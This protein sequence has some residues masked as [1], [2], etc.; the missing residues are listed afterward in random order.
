MP[1]H[2]NLVTK[3]LMILEFLV[4]R[5]VKGGERKTFS[6]KFSF[7]PLFKI[8]LNHSAITFIQPSGAGI[9]PIWMPVRV[10]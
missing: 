7:L 4:I 3:I 5:G 2:V 1:N 9:L 6:K 8:K 10:S